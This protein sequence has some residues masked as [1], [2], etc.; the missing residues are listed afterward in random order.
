MLKT[1]LHIFL[2]FCFA[3]SLFS[4]VNVSAADGQPDSSKALSSLPFNDEGAR[5]NSFFAYRQALMESVKFREPERFV[6]MVDIGVLGGHNTLGG[7]QDFAAKWR[8][9]AIDSPLWSTMDSLLSLGGGFVR[10]NKG[11]QF[12]APY[13]FV[14]FPDELDLRA[15]GV[16]IAEQARLMDEPAF[17]ASVLASLD[18][19]LVRVHDWKGMKVTNQNGEKETWVEVTSLKG[20][21]GW[22][23]RSEVRSPLDPHACFL[24]RGEKW[25]MVSLVNGWEAVSLPDQPQPVA[26]METPGF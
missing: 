17:N 2:L 10:S 22:L 13:V 1:L 6:T 24:L 7:M 15:H 5:D 20:P 23:P 18:H 16:V 9:D 14:D 8:I 12:C 19:D 25:S 11:V 21:V 3:S 4:W 26:E